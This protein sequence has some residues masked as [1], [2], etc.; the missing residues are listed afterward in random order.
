MNNLLLLG[1]GFRVLTSGS[2][3]KN[4]SRDLK[5][6]NSEGPLPS[7]KFLPTP[8]SFPVLCCRPVPLVVKDPVLWSQ[9][10]FLVLLH[11]SLVL[12]AAV[13]RAAAAS[14]RVRVLVRG[15]RQRKTSFAAEKQGW[16]LVE[17]HAGY[18]TCSEIG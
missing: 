14:E 2:S 12:P 17:G 10:L 18:C 8:V 9:Q 11:L 7:Q 3:S 13:V 1:R 16:H 4:L 5:K 15:T 6:C